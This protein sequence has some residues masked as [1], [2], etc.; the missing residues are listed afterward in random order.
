M[1]DMVPGFSAAH[2]L[3]ERL[4]KMQTA[5]ADRM[6]DMLTTQGATLADLVTDVAVVKE[7]T[8]QV[9]KMKE[10]ITKLE[11]FK[12]KVSLLGALSAFII[13]WALDHVTILHNLF[14]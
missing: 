2:D 4:F 5:Q 12:W 7:Q 10:R 6:L 13:G 14:K 3:A 9:P 8:A 11:E 1:A